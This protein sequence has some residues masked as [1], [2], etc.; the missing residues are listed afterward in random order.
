M[1]PILVK[2]KS[3]E[4][5]PI[6]QKL[7][8]NFK[9]SCLVCCPMC[10]I[11]SVISFDVYFERTKIKKEK[12]VSLNFVAESNT[13]QKTNAHGSLETFLFFLALHKSHN[14]TNSKLKHSETCILGR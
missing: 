12:N 6:S 11:V 10:F 14:F 9:I 4:E 5:G 1:G 7:Q 13:H 8:K 2:K 3:L